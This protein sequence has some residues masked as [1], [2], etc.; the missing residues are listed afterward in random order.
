MIKYEITDNSAIIKS[1]PTGLFYLGV[2]ILILYFFALIKENPLD[3]FTHILLPSTGILLLIISK[4]TITEINKLDN[5]VIIKRTF[6]T[7]E[8]VD[9]FKIEDIVDIRMEYTKSNSTNNSALFIKTKNDSYII[10]G[11]DLLLNQYK[12]NKILESELN[13]FIKKI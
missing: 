9:S 8:S 7:K 13:D 1:R 5:T 4:T 3:L 2:A 10:S 6:L 11:S 12:N